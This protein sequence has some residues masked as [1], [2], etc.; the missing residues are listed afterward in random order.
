[1]SISK[2]LLKITGVLEEHVGLSFYPPLFLIGKGWT[3]GSMRL[4]VKSVCVC[5]GGGQN[6]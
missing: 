2:R 6:G 4:W 5:G 1:M 3:V